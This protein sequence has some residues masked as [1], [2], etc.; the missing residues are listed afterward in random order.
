MITLVNAILHTAVLSQAMNKIT[1]VSPRHLHFIS[2]IRSNN[3]LS[4]AKSLMD[5]ILWRT[6]IVRGVLKD[7]DGLNYLPW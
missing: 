3:A 5:S 1:L 6:S 4:K 2:L 7:N